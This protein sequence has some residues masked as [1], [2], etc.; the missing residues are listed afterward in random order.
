MTEK[1]EH[2]VQMQVEAIRNIKIDKI[3]VWDSASGDKDGTTT[4]NF[5][6]GLI[7][8]LPPLHDVAGMAGIELPK[9]LGEIS[10]DKMEKIVPQEET[11]SSEKA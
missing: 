1:I 4:A 6:S 9:Y 5:L 2:I 10:P 7:K 3:T 11:D 8:S